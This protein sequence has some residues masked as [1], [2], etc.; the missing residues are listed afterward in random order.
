MEHAS[1]QAIAQAARYSK[2]LCHMDLSLNE[3]G[4][5]GAQGLG[6]ALGAPARQKAAEGGQRS[7]PRTSEVAQSRPRTAHTQVAHKLHRV[8]LARPLPCVVCR[9]RTLCVWRVWRR[10]FFW[11]V[12]SDARH[13]EESRR[14]PST[15]SP[16]T[17]RWEP[18]D[19]GL[20]MTTSASLVGWFCLTSRGLQAQG[21][22]L[23][24]KGPRVKACGL[25]SR[26][27]G[28]RGK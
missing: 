13:H 19:L 27:R 4:D 9:V 6:E 12:D 21:L 18:V 10:A 15:G 16:A 7:R 24:V 25:H 3:I 28:A 11:R 2:S 8:V 20:E 23:R 26:A 22:E 1:A 14:A 17:E 5:A